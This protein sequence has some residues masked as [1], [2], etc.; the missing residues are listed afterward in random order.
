MPAS[1][2]L[3]E[4]CGWHDLAGLVVPLDEHLALAAQRDGAASHALFDS[5]PYVKVHRLVLA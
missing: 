2:Q 3:P 5:L 1:R 4:V